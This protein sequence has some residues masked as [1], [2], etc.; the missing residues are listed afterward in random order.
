M[1]TEKAYR[2]WRI[3]RELGKLSIAEWELFDE[4]HEKILGKVRPYK[5]NDESAN[6]VIDEDE[7]TFTEFR[8]WLSIDLDKPAR[9]TEMRMLSRTDDNGIVP[10]ALYELVYF[11][12][13]GWRTVAVQKAEADYIEFDSV[14]SGALYWLRNLTK[15]TEERIF[16]Y[17]N[18]K[19]RYW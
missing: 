4:A 12:K 16:T 3:S 2:Y 17:E 14:P 13:E 18:G 9:V 11:G 19:V 5:G 7:L 15:G 6:R 10:G 8:S 1:D